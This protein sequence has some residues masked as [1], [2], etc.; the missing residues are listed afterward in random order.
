M[1]IEDWDRTDYSKHKASWK[2]KSGVVIMLV[3]V[4]PGYYQLILYDR[5]GVEHFRSDPS[6]NKSTLLIECA[7]WQRDYNKHL[8]RKDKNAT[9]II[10]T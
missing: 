8:A 6:Y 9:S 3:P 7:K 10:D 2:H 1:K 4:G 5:S